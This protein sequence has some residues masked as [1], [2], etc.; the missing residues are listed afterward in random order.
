MKTLK[1]IG[2][3]TYMSSVRIGDE[4]ILR[5]G[6][7]VTVEDE[8]ANAMLQLV[9][10]DALQNEHPLFQEVRTPVT[11]PAAP[12]S[13]EEEDGGTGEEEGDEDGMDEGDKGETRPAGRRSR[14]GK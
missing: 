5:R 7:T 14:S 8:H 11:K 3:N 12:A 4:R 1:L 2:A 9:N 6:E 13:I 10:V